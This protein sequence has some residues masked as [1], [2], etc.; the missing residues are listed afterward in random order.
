MGAPETGASKAEVPEANAP[1]E[2]VA[3]AEVEAAERDQVD[4]VV[5]A[6]VPVPGHAASADDVPVPGHAGSLGPEP[7]LDPGQA[8][9]AGAAGDPEAGHAV[10]DEDP[11]L[12][13]PVSSS[14]A[15]ELHAESA[16]SCCAPRAV[17]AALEVA[18]VSDHAVP[19]E[20]PPPRGSDRSGSDRSE[21]GL[22]ELEP[23][24]SNPRGSE[25]KGSTGRLGVHT[26]ASS[27]GRRAGS[28]GAGG[29][30][31][32]HAVSPG[33]DDG[34]GHGEP[35]GDWEPGRADS[36][37]DA[38]GQEGPEFSDPGQSGVARVIGAAGRAAAGPGS[39][40]GGAGLANGEAEG[41]EG[42]SGQPGGISGHDASRGSSRSEGMR[43]PEIMPGLWVLG[44]FSCGVGVAAAKPENAPRNC[45]PVGS[46]GGSCMGRSGKGFAT[47]KTV[48]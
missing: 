24:G 8:V 15:G 13:H 7:E 6:D 38:P 3:Q 5:A 32:I 9:S 39:P 23:R 19:A 47:A 12:D 2:G 41:A 45:S 10:S 35:D 21:S 44:M 20:P 34:S 46:V 36:D 27:L 37:G 4:S 18:P 31:G 40:K 29:V 33:A 48:D 14:L 25:P 42:T 1:A 16:G 28:G 11:E 22:S 43:P 26:S 17:S 30:A